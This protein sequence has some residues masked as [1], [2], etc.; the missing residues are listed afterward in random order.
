MKIISLVT[1]MAFS[2][3]SLAGW[4]LWN[5]ASALNFVSTV[6]SSLSEVHSFTNMD[7][8]ISETGEAVLKVD[9]AS[10]ETN[11][12]LRNKRIRK[13][14]FDTENFQELLISIKLDA[15][16]FAS[17]TV[18]RPAVMEVNTTIRLHGISKD[19]TANLLVT[20][21][22]TGCLLITSLHPVL[23]SL[24]DFGLLDNL[25]KLRSLAKVES[26]ANTVPVTLN[27]FYL[28]DPDENR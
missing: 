26:I 1:L 16:Q 20:R 27:L 18:S 25:E 19:I 11:N 14:I 2:T 23:V 12:A 9:L 22:Q 24:A 10:V 3:T 5:Q 21:L 13:I 8:S 7:G 15:D 4:T 6:N 28:K 17:L